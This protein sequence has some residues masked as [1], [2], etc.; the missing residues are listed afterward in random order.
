MSAQPFEAF[1]LDLSILWADVV[2]G[3]PGAW[4]PS[5]VYGPR[6]AHMGKTISL[7]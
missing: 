1:E 2:L 6:A 5:S 4:S 3:E 7:Q